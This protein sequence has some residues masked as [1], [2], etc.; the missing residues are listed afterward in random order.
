MRLFVEYLIVVNSEDS[1][2][3]TA[4]DLSDTDSPIVTARRNDI[5]AGDQEATTASELSVGLTSTGN[6]DASYLGD[7][8]QAVLDT[9]ATGY[10]VLSADN[11]GAGDCISL[12]PQ[13]QVYLCIR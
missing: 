7:T 6:G 5:D 1:W 3:K 9:G 2:E 12:D 11:I 10:S 4:T 13:T 8:A